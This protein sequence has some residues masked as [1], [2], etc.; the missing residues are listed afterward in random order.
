MRGIILRSICTF[1]ALL[2]LSGAQA[3]TVVIDFDGA[4]SGGLLTTDYVED[5]FTMESISGH[6]DIW[7]SGGTG[8]SQYLG[9]DVTLE[10]PPSSVV[11]FTGGIF[12]LLSLD[13]LYEPGLGES[14]FITSSAGG[15]MSLETLG[16]QNFSGSGWTDLTWIRLSNNIEIGGPGFDTLTLNT[17]PVPAAIWLFGSALGLLGW[18]RRKTL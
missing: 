4:T 5:G 6:Y 2:M 10:D 16:I 1:A 18:M 14:Q 13:V 3:A 15:S 8:G 12:D 9:L 17:V 7:A 11:E